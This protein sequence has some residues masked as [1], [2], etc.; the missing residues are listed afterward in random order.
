MLFDKKAGCCTLNSECDDGI[1]CTID[2][3]TASTN[4]AKCRTLPNPRAA[5]QKS[6]KTTTLRAPLSIC[7]RRWAATAAWS[8]GVCIPKAVRNR[9]RRSLCSF[10]MKRL[11]ITTMRRWAK[12]SAPKAPCARHSSSSKKAR[13]STLCN[14][15]CFGN[16]VDWMLLTN[17]KNPPLVGKNKFDYFS[18]QVY[19]ENAFHE[20]WSSD[21]ISGSTEGTWMPIVV[22]LD[23]WK[24]K[25]VQV[26]LSFDTGDGEVNDKL[27]PI[28]DNFLVKIACNK[29]PA[30]WTGNARTSF[31]ARAKRRSALQ[32]AAR[33]S[34]CAKRRSAVPARRPCVWTTLAVAARFR[35]VAR[36]T[37]T[38]T[39]KTC[40]PPTPAPQMANVFMFLAVQKAVRRNATLHRQPRLLK[41]LP[42][43][44]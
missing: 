6:W 8:S 13:C 7:G 9:R 29:S 25:M 2:T 41:H 31:A 1:A 12:K 33:A 23:P 18:V 19:F 34:I 37:V 16:G 5:R 11:A 44:C 28:V 22:S 14:L 38:A 21:V 43:R 17:Y 39:T 26:C 36:W 4:A 30:I 27:G 32:L 3:C 42:Q 35:L 40:A 15:T 24:G 20:A 10:P